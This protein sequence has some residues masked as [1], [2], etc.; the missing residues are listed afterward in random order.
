MAESHFGARVSQEPLRASSLPEYCSGS[1]LGA[2][3]GRYDVGV[4]QALEQAHPAH[5]SRFV[6]PRRNLLPQTGVDAAVE[7]HRREP[8]IPGGQIRLL[9]RSNRGARMVRRDLPSP[10]VLV[11][12]VVHLDDRDLPRAQHRRTFC[13]RG[14]RQRVRADPVHWRV[15][16]RAHF[17]RS[18]ERDL[19]HRASLL[20]ERS[21]LSAAGAPSRADVEIG[22]QGF[23]A[24]DAQLSRS[25]ARMSRRPAFDSPDAPEASRSVTEPDAKAAADYQVRRRSRT[26]FYFVDSKFI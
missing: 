25:A 13:D 26:E 8:W 5:A 7:G 20:P 15:P 9:C 14:P 18:E 4:S 16:A 2:P 1:G 21:L 24:R 6:R 22:L 12:A 19:P 11:R 3:A 10:D 23:R 17:R